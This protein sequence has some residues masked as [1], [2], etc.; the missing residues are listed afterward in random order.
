MR[1]ALLAASALALTMGVAQAQSQGD[2]ASVLVQLR[3]VGR[4]FGEGWLAG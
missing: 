2:T 3:A 1:T 4:Y